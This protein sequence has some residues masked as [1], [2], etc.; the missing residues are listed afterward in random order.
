MIRSPTQI[1]TNHLIHK[2]WSTQSS[3]H[4]VKRIKRRG[5]EI[6]HFGGDIQISPPSAGERPRV[7]A[8]TGGLRENEKDQYCV[9]P[10]GD[11]VPAGHEDEESGQVM[12]NEEQ[13]A[14]VKDEVVD[15][16]HGEVG[17]AVIEGG[18][19]GIGVGGGEAAAGIGED[20]ERGKEDGGGAV[21]KR[22]EAT[23][24]FGAELGG[25]A[26]EDGEVGGEV[27]GEKRCEEEREVGERREL[28]W[29]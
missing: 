23:G 1:E 25:P 22:D 5:Q 16:V 18:V 4:R 9:S 24:G 27:G 14:G 2:N 8:K 13:V 6:I 29:G 11:Q 3:N 17:D 20:G 26:A 21:E 7:L 28:D 19:L 12:S 15:E 10:V